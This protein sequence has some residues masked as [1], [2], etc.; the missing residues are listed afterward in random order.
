MTKPKDELKAK[1][2]EIREGYARRLRTYKLN[3]VEGH[4]EDRISPWD[5]CS[6]FTKKHWLKDADEWLAY[7]DSEG[8]VIKGGNLS[9][10]P[11][12]DVDFHL[13]VAFD[14]GKYS[15]FNSLEPLIEDGK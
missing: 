10:N 7:L 5:E 12:R 14:E 9:P 4:S 1:Q 3:E 13:A 15:V 11:Y 2:E 6:A 8:V